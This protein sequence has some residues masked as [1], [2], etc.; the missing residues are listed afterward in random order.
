MG[1]NAKLSAVREDDMFENE[2]CASE[3][4]FINFSD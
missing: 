3:V 1:D 2:V 4:V